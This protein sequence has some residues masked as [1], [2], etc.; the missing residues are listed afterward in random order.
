MA[1]KKSPHAQVA[2]AIDYK[3]VFGSEEGKRV[4][5]DILKSCGMLTSSFDESSVTMAYKE[6]QRNVAL[7]LL[8]K[9]KVNIQELTR[10]IEQQEE[11]E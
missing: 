8:H 6:G 2:K 5:H 10:F 11:L 3:V 4:L 9:T 7:S 1:K